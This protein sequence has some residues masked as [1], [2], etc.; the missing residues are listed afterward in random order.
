ML[1]AACQRAALF[2][3]EARQSGPEVVHTTAAKLRRHLVDLY[4][5]GLMT[6]EALVIMAWFITAAGGQGVED[7]AHGP[8]TLLC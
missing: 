8:A 5:T 3:Q 1:R 2:L 7:L 6:A 4:T